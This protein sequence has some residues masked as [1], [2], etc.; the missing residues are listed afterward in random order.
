MIKQ[1]IAI[2]LCACSLMTNLNAEPKLQPLVTE[3]IE[4][5]I[6]N[7]QVRAV[8]TA[9]YDNGEIAYEG[10]GRVADN[11]L[12]TPNETTIFEIGSIS[13]V[14]TALLA[15][16]LIDAGKLGWDDT[17]AERFPEVKFAS[18]AVG[19]ISLR[20]LASHRSGLPRLPDNLKPVDMGD[21][22]T[23]YDREAL[24]A[25]LSGYKPGKLKRQYEYSNLGAGILGEVAADAA[26]LSFVDAT[27][28]HVLAPLAM[29]SSGFDPDKLGNAQL[30]I[31]FSA[32]E[33]AA[34]WTSSNALAGAGS[35]LSTSK[36]LMS[37]VRSN[38]NSGALEGALAS[39]RE[40]EYKGETALGWHI[41][42][43]G[44]DQ[45]TYWHNGGTGGY[46]SF[47]AY[48]PSDGKAFVLLSTS[49]D[50]DL[51]T[52]LGFAQ[53]SGNTQSLELVELDAYLGAYKVS[54][55]F[56]LFI[57]EEDDRLMAQATGQAA[58]PLSYSSE[59]EF[60]FQGADIRITF[61][62][63]ESD[64]A[65]GLI[66]YQGDSKTK[67]KRAQVVNGV[68]ALLETSINTDKLKDY[69][70]RYQLTPTV[71][72]VVE[73]KNQRL[74]VRLSHQPAHPVYAY[75]IDKFFYKVVD[76]QLEFERSDGKVSAVIL[77]QNGK[78][79]APRIE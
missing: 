6:A 56:Y 24:L 60:V 9:V 38:L 27:E 12:A 53:M 47:L 42:D 50:Y 10:F 15:Q 34:N 76:A 49:T 31:G 39:I 67:A 66:L 7:Q 45:M 36:D 21:P 79:K 5:A 2:A 18:K 72:I 69:L 59:N 35:L 29:E 78:Q 62:A 55:N 70:G 14:F 74:L 77:H 65:P 1:L 32:G 3:R 46:A 41:S 57:T 33:D 22:F 64:S 23:A 58:F 75:D 19:A 61:D 20:E 73:E 43:A 17:L 52:E 37:F 44:T 71:E 40:A 54:K 63:S 4:R 48:R 28:K 11:N 51:I 13:K 8:S 16:T 26:G 25:F 68:P 30:A